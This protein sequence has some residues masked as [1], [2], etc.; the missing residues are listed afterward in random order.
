MLEYLALRTGI[1]GGDAYPLACY[2]QEYTET[3]A[4]YLWFQERIIYV[5][6]HPVLPPT[7]PR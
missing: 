6:R 4:H 7:S 3:Y 1:D 2:R 5:N